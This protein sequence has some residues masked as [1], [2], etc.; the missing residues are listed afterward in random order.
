M[1]TPQIKNENN[2]NNSFKWF[3]LPEIGISEN[4]QYIQVHQENLLRE[5]DEDR[6]R[7]IIKDT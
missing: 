4:T 1:R 7:K 3:K 6:N 2:L 5:I